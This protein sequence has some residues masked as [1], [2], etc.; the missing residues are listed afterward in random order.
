MLMID[1]RDLRPDQPKL[2]Q[3][4]GGLIVMVK[5]Q[6]VVDMANSY[7]IS[8]FDLF[9]LAFVWWHMRKPDENALKQDFTQYK[10]AK[11]IP[12]YVKQFVMENPL[13]DD[14]GTVVEKWLSLLE[15]LRSKNK[16]GDSFVRA[17]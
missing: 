8:E 7:E 9:W 5:V 17:A 2:K 3:P 6:D 10:I 15:K 16:G 11:R 14:T 13:I 1:G 12:N 4:N